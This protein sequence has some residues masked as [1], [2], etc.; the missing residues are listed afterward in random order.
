M[1]L[2]AQVE[3]HKAEAVRRRLL[4]KGMLDGSYVPARDEEF[5]YFAVKKRA[6]G[7]DFAQKKLKKRQEYGKSLEEELA[8]KL[9]ASELGELVKSFDMIGDI[10]V[11][12]I[13]APL[14][15]KQRLIASAIMKNHRNIRTVAKKTGGTSGEF[16]IRPVRVIAGARRTRTIYREAGCEFELDLNKTYFS[17]RLGTERTRIASLVKPGE[18]VLVPFAGAGPFAIRIAKMQAKANVVGIELNPAAAKYFKSNIKRNRCRNVSAVKGDVARL[19]PGK[20]QGKFDRI[21]MP[22]PKDGIHFLKNVLPCLKKGG[23]LHYYAFGSAVEPFAE[24]EM[25]VMDAALDRGRHAHLLF[26]RIVR[27]YSKTTVQVVIDTKIA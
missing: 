1:V 26:R 7:F 23:V 2:C 21:A 27:P 25:Q 3:R 14:A 6:A 8:G 15:K 19:L 16:R 13:P 17:P 5:V 4:D 12:E 11:V 9:T 22:L 18:K 10:A 20:L 24:A